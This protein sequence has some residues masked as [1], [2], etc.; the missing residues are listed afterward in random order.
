[1]PDFDVIVVG[2]GPAGAVSALKCSE[3]GLNVLLIEKGEFGRHKP[4]G[5]V[6]PPVCADV[7]SESLEK[8]IPG[9]TMCSPSTLGL[10]YVPPSG[11]KNGGSVKNYRLLNVNRDL[12]DQWLCQLA[13]ESGVKIW[14]G[15]EF[16]NL[17]RS[18]SIQISA[19][20]DGSTVKV[21]TRYLI[22]AD[23]VYS[24]VR[25]Q[26]YG[27]IKTRIMPVLQEHWQASGNI[28]EHFYAF[29][30]GEVSST[31]AYVIPKDGLYVVGLGV[32]GTNSTICMERFKKWLCEEFA[33][34][35]QSLERREVWAIPY[36]FTLEGIDNVILA[37]DAAGFCNALS[38]EGIRLAIESG[39]AASYAVRD[40]LSCNKRLISMYVDHVEWIASF[41]RRV[42]RFAIGLTDDGREE[43][44]K[45]ELAR[46]PLLPTNNHTYLKG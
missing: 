36:G 20:K 35:P 17:R 33:F 43:F 45:S 30:C 16:L 12:F 11:R 1:M 23:G 24:R 4:C 44:V 14:W 7:I 26:L 42:Y 41:V 32:S 6:L 28:D 40:A 2:G 13:I 46:F 34:K 18:E 38:G 25:K 29:F 10:Y 39:V 5:G 15:T 3:I 27:G 9:N 8:K 31:Y 19:T 22:G 37:G 21:T